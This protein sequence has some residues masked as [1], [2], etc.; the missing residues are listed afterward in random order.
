MRRPL[1]F[2]PKPYVPPI[3]ISTAVTL[4]AISGS[5]NVKMD[6]VEEV[7]RVR[8]NAIARNDL[9]DIHIA[10]MKHIAGVLPITEN[11][12][13]K[14]GIFILT[15]KPTY[16]GSF[17]I[18]DKIEIIKDGENGYVEYDNVQV[19][20]TRCYVGTEINGKCRVNYFK[21]MDY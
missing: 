2:N 5:N 18:G 1:V 10:N 6:M 8:Y 7:Y 3:S 15:Y 9:S 21:L 12:H 19:S 11:L 13:I 17:F 20:G 14:N 4:P 16:F